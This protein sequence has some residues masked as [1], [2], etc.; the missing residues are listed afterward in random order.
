MIRSQIVLISG[1]VKSHGSKISLKNCCVLKIAN[2]Y[3]KIKLAFEI[4]KPAGYDQ[5]AGVKFLNKFLLV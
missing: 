3:S 1:I 5:N 4:F 2:W